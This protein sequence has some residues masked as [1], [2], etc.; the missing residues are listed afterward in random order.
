MGGSKKKKRSR[1]LIKI[2]DICIVIEFE[3]NKKS[4]DAFNIFLIFFSSLSLFLAV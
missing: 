4:I 3:Q 2:N 1:N